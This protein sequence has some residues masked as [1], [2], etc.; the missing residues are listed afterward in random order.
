MTLFPGAESESH[1]T[2]PATRRAG[3]AK[4]SGARKSGKTPA[5]SAASHTLILQFDGG[6]RG[7]PGPAGIGV[8]LS[9]EAGQP[10]YERSE[11]LGRCTNNVAEYTA[12]LRGLHA[13]AAI[14]DGDA[15]AALL[16]RSDS[17]LLVRQLNG[18]YKVKSP[19]LKPLFQQPVILLRN[20][21]TVKISHVYRE[22]NTRA[23]QLA[24]LAM[25]SA[26]THEP[27]GPARPRR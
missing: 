4:R 16:I 13:A 3:G 2:P 25:D 1:D 9:D 7:N 12:L 26:G 22:G 18:I 5:P 15:A 8:T 19:D 11:F 24:N 10:V 14:L 23:D 20:F 27:L 21:G 17:E 6:S